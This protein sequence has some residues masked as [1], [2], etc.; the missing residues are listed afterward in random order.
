MVPLTLALAYSV[1]ALSYLS[2]TDVCRRVVSPSV[3]VCLLAVWV[4]TK[5]LFYERVLL[6][7][8]LLA[9][10]LGAVLAV[11]HI[12][13]RIRMRREAH[14]G[15]YIGRGD[16]LLLPTATFSLYGIVPLYALFI[17]AATAYILTALPHH[18]ALLV[19]RA[20]RG[21][22]LRALL[23]LSAVV[24]I[25]FV[26][27]YL[28]M[29]QQVV[30]LMT[31]TSLPPAM[32]TAYSVLLP[33]CLVCIAVS[34]FLKGVTKI[35]S[36][37]ASVIAARYRWLGLTKLGNGEVVLSLPGALTVLIAYALSWLVLV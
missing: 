35:S 27:W 7:S 10:A 3:I 21:V 24:Y 6:D 18:A 1:L 2:V 14:P 32:V 12:F 30:A 15:V 4:A 37:E 5:A 31:L 19:I 26:A 8:A 34:E 16:L 23:R 20:K 28:I 9:L 36:Q 33:L 13:G 29:S 17:I 11:A 25:P 22:P